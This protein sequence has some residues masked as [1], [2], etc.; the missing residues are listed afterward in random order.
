MID[1]QTLQEYGLIKKSR[2]YYL[3]YVLL[4]IGRIVIW[5]I[6]FGKCCKYEDENDPWFEKT[7]ELYKKNCD[8]EDATKRIKENQE[9]APVPEQ[10]KVNIQIEKNEVQNDIEMNNNVEPQTEVNVDEKQK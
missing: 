1:K 4:D 5:A 6:T 7:G 2:F 9:K 8:I 3:P 10:P